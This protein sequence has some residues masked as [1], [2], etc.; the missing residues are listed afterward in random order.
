MTIPTHTTPDGMESELAALV[1]I[2]VNLELKRDYLLETEVNS[3]MSVPSQWD[4]LTSDQQASWTTYQDDL[5]TIK[6][7][8]AG[9][10][11]SI[12]WPTKPEVT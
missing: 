6:P 4:A 10:P 5:N 11:L 1:T 12:T 9:W 3:I 8:C 7:M 2:C